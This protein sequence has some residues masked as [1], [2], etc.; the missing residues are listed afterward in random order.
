[1]SVIYPGGVLPIGEICLGTS[2]FFRIEVNISGVVG[3]GISFC[4]VSFGDV[5]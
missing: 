1:M 4:V 2:M 5:N 3:K